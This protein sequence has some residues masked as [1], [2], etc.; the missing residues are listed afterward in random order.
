MNTAQTPPETSNQSQLDELDFSLN[1][2]LA[3]FLLARNAHPVAVAFMAYGIAILSSFIIAISA[4]RFLPGDG[5]K[6][7]LEDGFYFMSETLLV[8]I[9]WGYYLWLCNALK[10]VLE[11]LEKTD[12]LKPE[13]SEILKTKELLKSRLPASLALIFGILAGAAYFYQYYDYLSL[14]YNSTPVFLAIRSFLIVSP[15][16]YAVGSIISRSIVNT[17][18]FRH[19]LKGVNVN[20]MHPD[21]SGGLLPLGQYALKS[22]YIIALAGVFA[23]LAEYELY[24]Q[25]QLFEFHVFHLAIL[26]YVIVAP[27]NFFAPLGTA[28]IAMLKAKNELLLKI[29][30]QFSNDF[31]VAYKGLDATA[32]E[33]KSIVD[34]VEQL[35]RIQELTQAFPV[36]PFDIVTLRRFAIT[37]SSPIW[38]ILFSILTDIVKSAITPPS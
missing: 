36:W 30:K 27:V 6:A 19:L 4:G 10:Q 2:R 5:Y 13:E 18:V 23:A 26:I 29:S 38:T 22:T 12:V 25:G 31:S 14:W 33:L 17:L 21:R 16:A 20:P 35:Q 32:S 24:T 7:L 34:K 3:R 9:V 1:D 11:K 28:R 8:P 37:V 15:S